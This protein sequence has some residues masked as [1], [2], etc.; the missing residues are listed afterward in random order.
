MLS[1]VLPIYNER[2]NLAPLLA[3]VAAALGRQA[4][5]VVAVD[6]SSTD[7]SLDEL[8]RLRARHPALRIVRLD[9]RAGQSAALSAAFEAVRGD[10]IVTMDADGQNDP[11][12]VPRLVTVLA[13]DPSLAAVTGYRV[14]R[15]DSGWKRLQSRVANVVRNRLTGDAVR[16]TGCGLRAMRRQAVGR[17]PRFDGMHRFL[18]TLIRLAGGTVQELP[19]AHRARRYG[20]SKYGM[21]NRAMRGL[22]DA[23]GV[24]W[25]RR[26][27]L[28]YT[29]WEDKA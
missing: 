22:R 11:A 24:R 9:R 23:L 16:D 18:P 29:M 28:R 13:G 21:W 10:V 25:L 19:V 14:R 5:E 3:E 15:A 27:E 12:D 17:L 7:G 2:E 6:D 20:R 8:R 26:R 4:Y 1:V